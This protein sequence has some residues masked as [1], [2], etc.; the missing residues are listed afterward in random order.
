MIS[1]DATNTNFIVFGLTRLGVKPKIYRTRG[2][3]ANH[4]TTDLIYETNKIK[5]HINDPTITLFMFNL[6]FILVMIVNGLSDGEVYM[7]GLVYGI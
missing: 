2:K 3:H 7:I 1:G 5:A 4:Y 6:S